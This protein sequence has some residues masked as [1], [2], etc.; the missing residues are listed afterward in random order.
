MTNRE[1]I[2]RVLGA[3]ISM[4]HGALVVLHKGSLDHFRFVTER[5]TIAKLDKERGTYFFPTTI[6]DWHERSVLR[7]AFWSSWF[8]TVFA[9]DNFVNRAT[10]VGLEDYAY[11]AGMNAHQIG[12][13]SG[14]LRLRVWQS[15]RALR[16]HDP[17]SIKMFT[18]HDGTASKDDMIDS[19]YT[20]WPDSKIFSRFSVGKFKGIE[21]DLC[22]AYAIAQLVWTEIQLR[23]GR[24]QLKSLDPQEVRVFNRCTK[25]WPVS[26]L[27]RDWLQWRTKHES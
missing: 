15:G 24:L 21:E 26:L 6:R 3:D 16:L 12:E 18:V 10:H 20:R 11:D 22:D 27:D 8:S 23:S 5:K 14:L 4:N 2:T 9:K 19:V 25:R 17:G 13:V 7:L 1:N